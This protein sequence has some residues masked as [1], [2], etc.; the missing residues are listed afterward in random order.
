M[1]IQKFDDP[2]PYIIVEDFLHPDELQVFKE[3]AWT[4][5]TH[6]SG[7]EGI[8]RLFLKYD[9]F[10]FMKN[11]LNEFP[12]H[13]PYNELAKLIHF[14]ATPPNM[15]HPMHVDSNYKIM[16]AVLY[17]WPDENGGTV[18]YKTP[19]GEGKEITWKPNTLFVFCGL[20]DV[21]H[22]TYYSTEQRYTL[23]YFLVDPTLI[24]D[25]RWSDKFVR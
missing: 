24:T 18:L 25:P 19:D 17:L 4:L 8:N 14:A 20:D 13:R 21:T 7:Y 5:D 3:T 11:L 16:S 9:P 1:N 15:T 2:W 22:H 6:Q 10:P 23:N 12:V